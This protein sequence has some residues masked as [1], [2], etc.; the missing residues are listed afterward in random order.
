MI[1]DF[2]HSNALR[3]LGYVLRGCAIVLH[4]WTVALQSRERRQKSGR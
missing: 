4:F 3:I 1:G 2:F